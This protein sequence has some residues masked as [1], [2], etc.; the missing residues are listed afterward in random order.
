MRITRHALLTG[1]IILLGLIT[2]PTASAAGC[3][4]K[5]FEWSELYP[6]VGTN[7]TE[8]QS[9]SQPWAMVAQPGLGYTTVHIA[10]G[11][12]LGSDGRTLSDLDRVDS[13]TLYESHTNE[14]VY[15]SVTGP[16]NWSRAGTYYWQMEATKYPPYPSPCIEYQSPIYSFVIINPKPAPT[17]AP[18]PAPQPTPTP[19]AP[20]TEI[21]T[22]REAYALVRHDIRRKTHAGAYKLSDT[23]QKTSSSKAK[24]R[25][26]WI[27][28][29][30]PSSRT[31]VYVGTFAVEHG[32]WSPQLRNDLYATFAGLRAHYGCARRLGVK[33]CASHVRWSG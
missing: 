8:G 13:L 21:L 6:P 19:P 2:A 33:R 15:R 17:P 22:L 24:C 14:G 7:F 23:C 32:E 26:T 29:P 30:H 9:E 20:P 31:L 28:S 3:E 11:P 10:S 25:A 5:P 27:A 1:V 18:A 16:H 12:L 4:Y